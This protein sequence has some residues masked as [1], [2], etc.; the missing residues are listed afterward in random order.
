M[1]GFTPHLYLKF[2]PKTMSNCF[3]WLPLLASYRGSQRVQIGCNLG[4]V[5]VQISYYS[6]EIVDL[7]DNFCFILVAFLDCLPPIIGA[8]RDRQ[9]LLLPSG[10]GAFKGGLDF[11]QFLLHFPHL[12]ASSNDQSVI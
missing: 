8:G 10:E 12:V 2:P 5:W 9:P 1:I 11:S 3:K 6:M 4:A 7:L